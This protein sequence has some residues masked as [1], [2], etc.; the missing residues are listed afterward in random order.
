MRQFWNQRKFAKLT[1]KYEMTVPEDQLYV[2]FDPQSKY[3]T[4]KSILP[5]FE[6]TEV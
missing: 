1:D 2:R 5:T 6:G 3:L 4:I